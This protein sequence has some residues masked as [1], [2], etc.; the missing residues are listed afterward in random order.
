M[1]NLFDG[2]CQQYYASTDD[3]NGAADIKSC[4]RPPRTPIRF[5]SNRLFSDHDSIIRK[6][7]RAA[8]QHRAT[9]RQDSCLNDDGDDDER[10]ARF[11]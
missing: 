8:R 7:S 10:Q 11:P 4:A 3:P 2:E 6:T 9:R 1:P 5:C